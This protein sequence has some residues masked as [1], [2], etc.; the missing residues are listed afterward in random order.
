MQNNFEWKKQKAN[1][2]NADE[3]LNK[4]VDKELL[5]ELMLK[6]MP[7]V[8]VFTAKGCGSSY[9]M[10]SIVKKLIPQFCDALKCFQ[11]D[12]EE[13]RID[14]AKLG[15]LTTPLIIF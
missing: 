11:V 15:F 13:K 1:A 6:D 12:I 3:F 8:I 4:I 9:I 5:A 2:L 14:L 7:H 10:V